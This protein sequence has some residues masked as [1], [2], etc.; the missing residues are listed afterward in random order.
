MCGV[1]PKEAPFAEVPVIPH[2]L[3]EKHDLSGREIVDLDGSEIT[4][5]RNTVPCCVGCN[6]LL[7]QELE[8]PMEVLMSNGLEA[9]A[10]ADPSRASLVI[11]PWLCLTFFKSYYRHRS[12]PMQSGDPIGLDNRDPCKDFHHLLEIA[13][14]PY[15]G[16][17]IEANVLGSMHVFRVAKMA[18]EEAFD[19]ADLY[20]GQAVLLRINDI[21][22][23]AVLNDSCGANS[24]FGEVSRRITGSVCGIQLRE[25]LAMLAAINL[26]IK[27][28]PE[29]YPVVDKETGTVK[30]CAKVPKKCDMNGMSQV[31][32]GRAM[33]LLCHERIE[34]SSMP[35]KARVLEE[36]I[37]GN[38]S[39]LF[40]SDGTFMKQ[41]GTE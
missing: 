17:L 2:W 14:S 22:I 25:I 36:I 15:S 21:G 19:F 11:F 37:T 5:A 18:S 31:L 27:E 35:Y 24:A 38:R 20:P 33:Y 30:I 12:M 4:Y 29:Y 7:N 1:K 41:G 26:D 40:Q 28:R 10:A 8:K 23:A 39:F 34:N 32:L 3:L 6:D 16:C 13:R 9:L